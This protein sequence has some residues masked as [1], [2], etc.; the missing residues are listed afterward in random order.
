MSSQPPDSHR[1]KPAAVFFSAW[2][3]PWLLPGVFLVLPLLWVIAYFFP[4]LNQDVA[5]ILSVAERWM[6]GERL[7]RDMIDVNPPLIFMLSLIPVAL[8]KVLPIDTA[9]ALIL[10]VLALTV[11]AVWA[12]YRLMTA[13]AVSE[14]N[15][16][17]LFLLPLLIFN[18]IVFPSEM[19]GQREHLMACAMIPYLLLAAMRCDEK[20]VSVAFA[21]MISIIAAIGFSLKPH[22]LMIVLAVELYLLFVRGLGPTLRDQV[23]WVM[24]MTM[25]AYVVFAWYV[26]PEYFSFVL[27]LVV[28]DYEAISGVSYF[29]IT[30]SK[31]L[32]PYLFVAI[33]LTVTAFGRR[34]PHV[35]RLTGIVTLA[36]ALAGV[37]QDKGWPYH[38]LPAQMGS[39]LLFGWAV[40]RMTDRLQQGGD[41][42]MKASRSMIGLML[43]MIYGLA[44]AVRFGLYDQMDYKDSQAGQWQRI[45]ERHAG[46]RPVLMLT[47]GI[48]PHF[49]AMNYAKLKEVSRFLTVWPLQGAYDGCKPEDSRYHTPE[50]M[51][52]AER[53]YNRMLIE[54]FVKHKPQLVVIDRIPGIPWCGGREFSF[55]EY[56]LM[57][58]D[59]ATEWRNYEYIAIYDRY[60]L[61]KRKPSSAD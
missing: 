50:Q 41:V 58:P 11:W 27:P 56:F 37:S 19:F 12:S 31:H 20:K 2:D 6:D 42:V 34:W 13:L 38:L 1:P 22:F 10:C 48:Y 55:L 7:Y 36:A 21:L 35:M 16:L 23:P 8:A 17:Q 32:G 60:F 44:G 52:Y 9:S 26:T 28:K 24:V 43:L 39:I 5:V 46:G 51:T 15:S 3:R 53:L 40:A 14:K 29:S 54:D 61:Y 30:T 18:L 59:F 57:Q 49:P 33:P 45:L 47:P 25:A 4:P